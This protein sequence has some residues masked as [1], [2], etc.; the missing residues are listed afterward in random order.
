MSKNPEEFNKINEL[1]NNGY[2][3]LIKNIPNRDDI[4]YKQNMKKFIKHNLDYDVKLK[5]KELRKLTS[6]ISIKI[7]YFVSKIN[8]EQLD[9]I[10]IKKE[11]I[12]IEN[13]LYKYTEH[14]MFNNI[15]ICKDTNL[16]LMMI[17]DEYSDPTSYRFN[18]IFFYRMAENGIKQ[19]YIQ[20]RNTI[21]KYETT[22]KIL[23]KM[24]REVVY[25]NSLY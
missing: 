15:K 7:N 17:Q 1:F 2:L 4:D 21:K 25:L 14:R 19:N 12:K 11:Y 3:N 8:S 6:H 23:K 22:L 18:F 9:Y 13:T 24:K 20:C 16:S 5:R 10:D